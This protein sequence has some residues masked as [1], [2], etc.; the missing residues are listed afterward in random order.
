MS[1]AFIPFYI[2]LMG[3]ESYGIVGVLLALQ[4]MFAVLD[5]GLSQTMAREMARLSAAPG[6]ADRLADTVRTLEVI[7]W[8]LALCVAAAIFALSH[9]ISHYW[10]NPDQLSRE[11][12]REALWIIA[13]VV[14]LRWPVALYIGGL[15]GLQ[16]Q[17]LVN[18]LLAIFATAQGV[19]ALAVLWFI[20]PTMR[21]FFWWQALIA[22]LQVVTLKIALQRNLFSERSGA[23]SVGVLKQVWRF[24]AGMT[25]ITLLATLLTQLDKVLL[26]KMLTLSEFGYYVFAATV[27]A[28]I[29]R[30]IG[31]VFTAYTP[32]LTELVSRKDHLELVNIYH[33]GCQVMALAI[34]TPALTLS[35]FSREILE[36]W[37]HNPQLVLSTHLLVSLLVIGNALNGLVTIPYALQLA[38]G[39]T[40]LSFY[41]NVFAVLLLVPAMY[42]ATL[43]WGAAGAASVWV[44]LNS[45]YILFGIPLMYRRLLKTEK[46]NW[47]DRDIGRPLLAALFVLTAARMMMPDDWGV[48]PKIIVLFVV[49]GLATAAVVLSMGSLRTRLMLMWTTKTI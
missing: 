38:H 2:R 19:G 13:L 3:V 45:G 12:L 8:G 6:N 24:A 46:W 9:S 42:F 4:A 36:L 27:A 1:L 15:N 22:L 48:I 40:R 33:Q 31:P 47:Y 14:G 18:V 28:S 41:S 11:S 20:E 21:A 39:W 30:L 43:S 35:M 37:T 7:Y 34:V 17:V 23:F 16:R 25:G 49:F 10:L 5:L 26:S 29:L 32:R 44:F